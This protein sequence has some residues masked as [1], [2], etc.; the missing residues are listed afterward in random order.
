MERATD[1]EHLRY[2]ATAGRVLISHDL[3]DFP[4]LA[5]R[6]VEHGEVHAGIVLTGQQSKA[7]CGD[8]LHRLLT[9]LDS[10]TAEDFANQGVWLPRRS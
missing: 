5:E 9:L 4:R 8:L 1:E 10:R 3:K 6:W 2:A 7:S